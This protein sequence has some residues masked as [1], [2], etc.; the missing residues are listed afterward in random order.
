MTLDAEF[1]PALF[2][3]HLLKLQDAVGTHRGDL[4]ED[5]NGQI[6]NV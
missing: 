5:K 1:L 4:G 6:D 2:N 3:H